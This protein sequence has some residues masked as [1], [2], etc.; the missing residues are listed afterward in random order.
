M[1]KKTLIKYINESPLLNSIFKYTNPEVVTNIIQLELNTI[2]NTIAPSKIIQYKANYSP[3]Y[4]DDIVKNLKVSH[5][6]LNTAIINND[7]NSWREFRNFRNTIDKTIK[8]K[9]TEYIRK[10]FNNNLTQWKFLKTFN[11]KNKQCIPSNITH[12]GKQVTSPKEIAT[13]A[14][15]FLLKK[16]TK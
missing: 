14:N 9:K 3:Y 1:Q 11:N 2:I 5:N 12:N 4:N 7:Q 6:L 10:K 15:I 8:I 16:F 13:I